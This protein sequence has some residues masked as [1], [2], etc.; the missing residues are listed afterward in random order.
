[1]RVTALHCKA[2]TLFNTESVLLV[3]YNEC[4]AFKLNIILYQSVRS[5]GKINRAVNQTLFYFALF[6]GFC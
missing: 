6:L 1:M 2:R 5:D 4:K 3:S